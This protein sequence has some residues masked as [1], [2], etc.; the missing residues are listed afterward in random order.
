MDRGL[1]G[2]L[3]SMPPTRAA[4]FW[5]VKGRTLGP[6]SRM[7][8]VTLYSG[9]L[10][11]A[12]PLVVPPPAPTL[13]PAPGWAWGCGEPGAGAAGALGRGEGLGVAGAPMVRLLRVRAAVGKPAAVQGRAGL[14]HDLTEQKP[15]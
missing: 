13:P 10:P 6:A 3:A 8:Y 2:M 11:S 4:C 12:V 5:G 14:T 1:S 15:K 9:A 7:Q